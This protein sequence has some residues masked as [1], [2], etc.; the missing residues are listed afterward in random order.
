[1][2][3]YHYSKHKFDK[4]DLSKFGQNSYTKRDK[5]VCNIPRVYFYRDKQ[6][7][8]RFVNG[9]YLYVCE[10]PEAGLYDPKIKADPSFVNFPVNELLRHLE[11]EGYDGIG[12]NYVCML[13]TDNIKILEV[14]GNEERL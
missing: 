7:R 8:E 4:F 12:Y 10:I 9:K 1:M 14:I 6:D 3:V 2:I 11:N 5:L 13:N